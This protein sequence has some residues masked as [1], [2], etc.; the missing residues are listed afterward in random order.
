MCVQVAGGD[1]ESGWVEH[2]LK[3]FASLKT[4]VTGGLGSIYF[5]KQ[6]WKLLSAYAKVSA[7]KSLQNNFK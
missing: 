4:F 3:S 7:K 6:P 1:D 2:A 5:I